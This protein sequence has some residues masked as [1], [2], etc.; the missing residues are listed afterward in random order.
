MARDGRLRFTIR[1]AGQDDAA[2]ICD[3]WRRSIHEICA[4]DY[5][6]V[7][8]REKW[9]ANKT[10]DNVVAWMTER[11]NHMLVAAGPDRAIVGVGLMSTNGSIGRIMACYIAPEVL[12]RGVGRALLIAMEREA[13]R[14]GAEIVR[15][16]STFTAQSFYRR[17]GYQVGDELSDEIPSIAMYK[18]LPASLGTS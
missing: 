7:A 11:K 18:H 12:G 6:D 4:A 1:P 17:N 2:R 8:M 5:P 16:R 15:L 14:R 9:A 3:V 10:P 13:V